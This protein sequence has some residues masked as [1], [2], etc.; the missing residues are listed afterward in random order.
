MSRYNVLLLVV[1]SLRA[2][3]VGTHPAHTPWLN[4]LHHRGFVRFDR[5]YSTACWTLPAHISMFTG[6]LPPAHNANF[7]NMSYDGDWPTVAETLADAGY[8]THCVT[9]NT[10]FDGSIPGVLRGFQTRAAPAKT[11][12]PWA[13]MNLLQALA[14]PAVRKRMEN[15]GFFGAGQK[16]S[17]EF[18]SRV[19]HLGVPADDLALE[20]TFERLALDRRTGRKSFVFTNLYDCHMPYAP[21][22]KSSNPAPT[23]WENI[24]EIAAAL[25]ALPKIAAH[26]YL[27]PGFRIEDNHARALRRRYRKAVER[28]DAMLWSFFARLEASGFL[29]DTVVILTSDHGEAFGEH[30]L[31]GHDASV[32][33]THLA[34]PLYIRHPTVKQERSS[35]CVSTVDVA[36]L[37]VAASEGAVGNL[38]LPAWRA[39]NPLAF[40]SHEPYCPPFRVAPE[41]SKPQ[42]AVK[43]AGKMKLV[44]RGDG[45]RIFAEHD[46]HELHAHPIE[47]QFAERLLASHAG[48]IQARLAI[49]F[50]SNQE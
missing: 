3:H 13:P 5:A 33:D 18:L 19:M 4:S 47:A 41:L 7:A 43:I 23:T 39:K 44:S 50:L 35:D 11:L 15:I 25:H 30:K 40:A 34:V 16:T 36:Q 12:D 31:W 45:I 42:R 26:K 14:K 8:G 24:H 9:R 6:V 32:Y 20:K 27:E 1:D 21:T 49:E 29:E 48:E 10:L 2:D 38:L 17:R 37:A 28:M 22:A 46:R